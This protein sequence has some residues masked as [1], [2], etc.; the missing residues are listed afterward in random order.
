MKPQDMRDMTREE[1]QHHLDT[2]AEELG[3]LKIKLAVKQLD[4]PLRVRVL[5]KEVARAKTVLRAKDMGAKPGEVH[6]AKS[7]EPAKSQG[8]VPRA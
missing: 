3:N 2:L 8:S 7:A 5:R 4:N 1:L 6:A